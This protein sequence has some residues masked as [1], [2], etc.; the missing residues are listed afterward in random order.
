MSLKHKIDLW[1]DS[2]TPAQIEVARTHVIAD[3]HWREDELDSDRSWITEL[4][5]REIVRGV[6]KSYPDGWPQFLRDFDGE[7]ESYGRVEAS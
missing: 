7:I 1:A 2:S 4:T 6:H 5:P 3:A